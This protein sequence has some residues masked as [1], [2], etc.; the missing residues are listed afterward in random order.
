MLQV[1][2]LGLGTYLPTRRVLNAELERDFGLPSG[3]IER[4]TGV[5]ERRRADH[6]TSVDI[7]CAAARAALDDAGLKPSDIDLILAASASP[8]QSVPCTASLVQNA[9]G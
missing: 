6:E 5:R 4:R 8:H 3:W 1:Q 9:L 2:I 7:A